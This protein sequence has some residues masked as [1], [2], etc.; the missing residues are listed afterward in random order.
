LGPEEKENR[1]ADRY[2]HYARFRNPIGLGWLAAAY[3]VKADE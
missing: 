2:D 1:K 3:L